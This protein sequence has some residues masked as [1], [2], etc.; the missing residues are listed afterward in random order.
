MR[1]G[2]FLTA[3]NFHLSLEEQLYILRDCGAKVLIVSA[4]QADAARAIL[5]EVPDLGLKLVFG[6]QIEGYD[7]FE[8]A[9]AD[10]TSVVA[11]KRL[12]VSVD[13]GGG[14]ILKKKTK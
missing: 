9:L 4:E 7:D 1:S 2:L 10:R 13:L 5:N 6:G 14:R 8:A 11:G 3:V 12:S